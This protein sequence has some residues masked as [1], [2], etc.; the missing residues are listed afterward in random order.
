[1]VENCSIGVE[2]KEKVCRRNGPFLFV[3]RGIPGSGKSF[4]AEA[5]KGYLFEISSPVE[6]LDPDSIKKEDDLYKSFTDGLRRDEP[7]L[8]PKIYPF[9][10]L[11]NRARETLL[12]RGIIIWNQ[13]FVDLDGLD[14]TIRKLE[15]C[16]P[17]RKACVLVIEV[18]TP[19]EIAKERV[20]RRIEEGG[21]G[22]K[23]E[24][25]TEFVNLYKSSVN[26]GY[27]TIEVDGSALVG[28]N[29][30]LI[31]KKLIGIND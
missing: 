31:R 2:D 3:I 21:H 22:P 30:S 8:D 11:I 4:L 15:D 28:Q 13:P 12:E 20:R 9:R 7:T 23:E 24:K 16:L 19:V 26:L 25:F 14:I 5:L 27:D 10:Y 18:V 1:M 29:V 6:V 17:E